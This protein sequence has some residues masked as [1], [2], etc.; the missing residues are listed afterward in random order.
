MF[1]IVSDGKS[2]CNS[3]FN[4]NSLDSLL[5]TLINYYEPVKTFFQNHKHELLDLETCLSSMSEN[6][7]KFMNTSQVVLRL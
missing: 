2:E 7:M 1:L 6:E 3:F 4:L 5:T